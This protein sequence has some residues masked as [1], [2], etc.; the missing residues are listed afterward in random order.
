MVDSNQP[1]D[2]DA[3]DSRAVAPASA[4]P[5]AG[6]PLIG[7]RVGSYVVRHRLKR[8]LFGR[9]YLGYDEL[10]AR[11]A[12]LEFVPASPDPATL[13]HLDYGVRRY[14]KLS[15]HPHIVSMYHFGAH[16]DQ[17]YLAFERVRGS[18]AALLRH[19]P[20]GLPLHVALRIAEQCAHALQFGHENGVL[21]RDI[22]PGNIRIEANSLDVRVAHFG[23]A[24]FY[25]DAAPDDAASSACQAPEQTAGL[26]CD[27]KTDV[28]ALGAI[29]YHCLCGEPL[30]RPEDAVPIARSVRELRPDAPRRVVRIITSATALQPR[31]RFDTAQKMARSIRRARVALRHEISPNEPSVLS[32]EHAGVG[33]ALAAVILGILMAIG[34]FKGAVPIDQA[35]APVPALHAVPSAQSWAAGAAEQG[36]P[37]DVP[38]PVPPPLDE[39]ALAVLGYERY[40]AGFGLVRRG[41]WPEA[42]A[43]LERA[44][45]LSPDDTVLLR[46][47]DYFVSRELAAAYTA[48][49]RCQEAIDLCVLSYNR[50]PTERA[51]EIIQQ[52]VHILDASGVP[53]DEAMPR[54][55]LRAE[56]VPC[57]L[58]RG[59]TDA[60]RLVRLSGVV[61]DDF[62]IRELAF[63]GRALLPPSLGQETP[64]QAFVTVPSTHM[65]VTVAAR[66]FVNP[67]LKADIVPDGAGEVLVAD[68]TD[69][70]D[71]V[72]GVV[73]RWR[74]RAAAAVRGKPVPDSSREL[75]PPVPNFTTAA[76]TKG[77]TYLADPESK[78]R[79]ALLA[80]DAVGLAAETA[81]DVRADLEK[82][83]QQEPYARFNV[84]PA[85]ALQLSAPSDEGPWML[86]SQEDAASVVAD[87]ARRGHPV[88]F[89]LCGSVVDHNGSVEVVAKLLDA[90]TAALVAARAAYVSSR[91]GRHDDL[92]ARVFALA[93]W[94][95]DALPR[96]TGLVGAVRRIDEGPGRHQVLFAINVTRE[97]GLCVGQPVSVFRRLGERHREV[98]RA[99]VVQVIE[100]GAVCLWECPGTL[101]E[102]ALARLAPRP[103]DLALV[104]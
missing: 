44:H 79:I 70:D 16:E 101:D 7:C 10:Q 45:T 57:Y 60:P 88:D 23:L 43:A 87:L 85:G 98:A 24:E 50:Q 40:V 38:P 59:Q 64:I 14:T 8:A 61:R 6:D 91:G 27:A 34:L 92:R 26:A 97:T 73:T 4:G 18:L 37:E 100:A 54:F 104:R 42:V 78:P 99:H 62:L 9:A 93:E 12:V 81:V 32:G 49:G 65:A 80:F 68:F 11:E 19:H 95:E 96:V 103:G 74:D 3:A 83:L 28:Y 72:A 13:A 52:A 102:A 39:K 51:L 29:L 75:P 15:V 77:S 33:V 89:L 17:R 1:G 84:I 48:I 63:G 90:R 30:P 66:D 36:L 20:E 86:P 46:P 47:L 31:K 67:V 56:R 58:P 2:G 76:V 69:R 55:E 5:P 41:L 71:P 21:H 35:F 94:I 53:V 22:R 25:R 82:A